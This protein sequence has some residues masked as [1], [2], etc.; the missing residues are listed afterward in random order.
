MSSLFNSIPYMEPYGN[1]I[2]FFYLLLALVPIVISL[3][4]GKK[5]KKYE[6]I[7]SIL[8]ILFM[9]GGDNYHQLG[10]FLFYIVWQIICVFGYK[11]YRRSHNQSIIFYLTVFASIFPLLLVKIIPLTAVNPTQSLFAF[12]GISYLTF[13]TVGMII[14][15]RDG[16]MTDFNLFTFIRFMIFLPTFSS[17][18][19]D[20]YRRFEED[21]KTIPSRDNYLKMIETAV[22]YIMLGFLYKFI[23]SYVLGSLLLPLIEAKALGIGGLFNRETLLVM[24]VYGLNLF[25]DFA[26]YSMFA[27]A[28]SYLMGIKTPQ[29]FNKPFLS[30]NL[31]EFWNRWHMSLSFWFRDYVYMRLVHALIKHKTFKNRNV[32]SGFAYIVNMTLMGFWHGLTWYYIAYGL[33][34]AI[35][36]IINDA[37]TR[38]KKAINRER[39]KQ[40]L[41]PRFESKAFYLFSVVLTFHVV[42]FS[43]LL[44]S[45]FLNV[46]WFNNIQK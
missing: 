13:K 35:G 44:F 32:T 19:I 28:I 46:L 22:M 26:G 5:L 3:L 20:R 27:I 10:A 24:Y 12:M 29:N 21:Y 4:N 43:L 34:H 30:V 14:E 1:P 23:I 16:V 11:N 37:W 36:L 33:F 18:P 39:K 9:F 45:G 41:A 42:M 6:F 15:M 40:G 17:G 38:K 25:F 31:K 8:F 7:V 2:Y